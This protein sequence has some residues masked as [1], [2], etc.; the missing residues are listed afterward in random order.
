[1]HYRTYYTNTASNM[2]N[3]YIMSIIHPNKILIETNLLY[4]I[5]DLTH[6]NK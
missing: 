4:K 3:F 2:K 6:T 5:T 1:M